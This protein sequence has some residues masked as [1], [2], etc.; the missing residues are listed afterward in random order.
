MRIILVT[1]TFRLYEFEFKN[2]LSIHRLS[3]FYFPAT[4]RAD[5]ETIFTDIYSI[6][7]SRRYVKCL[8]FIDLY[9]FFVYKSIKYVY[10]FLSLHQSSQFIL[11]PYKKTLP[12]KS[13]YL[14]LFFTDRVFSISC[15]YFYFSIS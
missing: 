10:R 2:F 3:P 9:A 1:P 5:S 13:R 7:T 15:T 12:V 14:Y 11:L 4:K 8:Y 6:F